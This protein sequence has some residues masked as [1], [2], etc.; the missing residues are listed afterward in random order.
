[1][2]SLRLKLQLAYDRKRVVEVIENRIS[3]DDRVTIGGN[4]TA[5]KQGTTKQREKDPESSQRPRSFQP[6]GKDLHSTGFHGNP[7]HFPPCA[8]NNLDAGEQAVFKRLC[9]YQALKS[10]LPPS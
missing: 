2:T 9:A 8:F 6:P 3:T 1:M 4:L 10:I 7:F 5:Y